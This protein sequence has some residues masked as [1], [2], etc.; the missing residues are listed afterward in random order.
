MP[1]A[2]YSIGAKNKKR[3]I[4]SATASECGIHF[5]DDEETSEAEE[6]EDEKEIE[7]EDEEEE[8]G[9]ED[10]VDLLEDGTGQED[11]EDGN[12]YRIQRH[13]SSTITEDG[14]TIAELTMPLNDSGQLDILSQIVDELSDLTL[15]GGEDGARSRRNNGCARA[16]TGGDEQ[17][18]KGKING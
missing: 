4:A 17:Q 15:G 5:W 11:A 7:A 10:A 14:G 9:E 3:H 13:H 16:G 18:S 2:K 6:A 8:E 12:H 1:M